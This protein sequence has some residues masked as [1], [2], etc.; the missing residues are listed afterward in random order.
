M[1]MY[2]S[3]SIIKFQFNTYVISVLVIFFLQIRHAAPTIDGIES[4]P[5]LENDDTH[6]KNELILEFFSFYGHNS[7]L[8]NSIVSVHA[9]KLIDA[10][11]V[12]DPNKYFSEKPFTAAE[13]RFVPETKRNQTI[14]K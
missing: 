13:Q 10:R 7:F 11:L 6:H 4:W 2:P 3:S 12:S 1:E 9:A 8:R 14:Q 5:L